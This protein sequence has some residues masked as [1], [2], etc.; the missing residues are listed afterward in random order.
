MLISYLFILCFLNANSQLTKG[1][2][3]L[4]GNGSLY[5]GK[6]TFTSTVNSIEV[7]AINISINPSI[8]YFLS[9][10]LVLGIRPGFTKN[11]AEL[12]PI[13]T[14]A[15][16][17]ENR[18]NFGPFARYYFLNTDKQFN[19]LADISYQYGLYWFTPTKGNR[20]TFSASAGTV[21]F[22]NSSIGLEFL[23]GYHSEKESRKDGI[24][25]ISKQQGLQMIVGF[26]LYLEKQ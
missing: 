20:H 5:S 10:K 8:G 14:G 9:D 18:L 13:G 25:S 19:L 3:L 6:N 17:N 2:W 23:I 12:I 4:G 1:N 11:K 26:Q 22:F 7:E 24:S 15:N 21:V 16:T